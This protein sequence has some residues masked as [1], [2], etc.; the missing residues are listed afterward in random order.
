MQK[1]SLGKGFSAQQNIK[2]DAMRP[3]LYLTGLVLAFLTFALVF[4]DNNIIRYTLLVLFVAVVVAVYY[5]N[6]YFAHNDTDRLHTE[7]YLINRQIVEA[8]LLEDK[9]IS[10]IRQNQQELLTSDLLIPDSEEV[11]N[12]Q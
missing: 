9:T 10:H 5:I 3:T 4:C 7:S 8:G 11:E 2:D 12:E 1:L 6:I